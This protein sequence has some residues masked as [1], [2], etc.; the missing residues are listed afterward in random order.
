MQGVCMCCKKVG[1]L[2]P[3]AVCGAL[4]CKDCLLDFGCKLCEGRKMME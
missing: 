1:E 3:C 2:F 4:V